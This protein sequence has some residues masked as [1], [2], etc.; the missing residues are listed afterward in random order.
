MKRNARGAIAGVIIA[1]GL[2]RRMGGGDKALA[3][4]AGEPMIAHVIARLRPQVE[5]LAINANG[6]PARFTAFG[7]PLLPDPIDGFIGPLAGLLAA[8]R[9]ATKMDSR[10]VLTVPAD[11]PFL[12]GDLVARLHDGIGNAEIAVARSGGV[13]HPTIA[14]WN[15]ALAGELAD[16]LR[17]DS[18]RAMHE[19]MGARRTVPVDFS[20]E[21]EGDPFFNVNTPADLD[22]ARDRMRK[23]RVG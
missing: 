7:L 22:T 9:W 8:L 5:A 18:H 21:G 14:L 10:L 17:D 20:D 4:L 19:W 2:S 12:P 6:D 11:T 16:W 3:A 23:V 1:G 15:A 13:I